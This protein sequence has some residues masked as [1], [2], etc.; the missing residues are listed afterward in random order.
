MISQYVKIAGFF[1]CRMEKISRCFFILLIPIPS[2]VS[3]FSSY[4]TKNSCILPTSTH[5]IVLTPRGV[6]GD[7][8]SPFAVFFFSKTYD[9]FIKKDYKTVQT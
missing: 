5:S 1:F 9:P 8:T 6:R 2:K 7:W 3:N 4:S